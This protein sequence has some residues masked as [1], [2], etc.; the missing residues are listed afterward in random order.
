MLVEPFPSEK[1]SPKVRLSKDRMPVEPLPLPDGRVRRWKVAP[2]EG[3]LKMPQNFE[4]LYL[5]F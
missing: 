5:S 3:R 1:S 4:R 2:N